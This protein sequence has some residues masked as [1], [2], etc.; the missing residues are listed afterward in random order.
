M[1]ISQPQQHVY[2]RLLHPALRNTI[3]N[4][5][6]PKKRKE[7]QTLLGCTELVHNRV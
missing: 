6:D 3:L 4:E 1:K 5:T 2:L 7:K